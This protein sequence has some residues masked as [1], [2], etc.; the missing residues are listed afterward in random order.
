[1]QDQ[2]DVVDKTHTQHLICLIKHQ[3]LDCAQI[4]GTP[5]Q[6][7]KQAAR[8]AHNNMYAPS[9]CLQLASH[10][11]PAVYRQYVEPPDAFRI[12]L[13]CL[14]NLYRQ[15]PGRAQHQSLGIGI[16]DINFCQNR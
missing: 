8:S 13:E 6:V 5:I 3:C 16:I 1:M 14:G 10:L 4:K 7:I 12:G 2:L 11:L 9:Q 15:L